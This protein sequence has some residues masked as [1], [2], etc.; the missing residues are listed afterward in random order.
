MLNQKNSKKQGDVGLGVMIGWL[1]AKGYT[2]SIPL[3][4]SQDYDLVVE[5][6]HELKKVQ[7]KTTTQQN[8]KSEHYLVDLRTNGGNRTGTGKTKYFDECEVDLLMILASNGDKYMIPKDQCPRS[9]MVLAPKWDQYKI[10]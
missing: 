4:D 6:E 10:E 5:M 2:V 8:N 3:T 1:T 7:V 9:A